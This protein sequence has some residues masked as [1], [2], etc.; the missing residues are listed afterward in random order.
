MFRAMRSRP[1]DHGVID[2]R[3]DYPYVME[4]LLYN[5]AAAFDDAR[6]LTGNIPGWVKWMH[7]CG[8]V[9]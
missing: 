8:S 2:E 9:G 7:H 5:V 3:T 1:L 4:C 6:V